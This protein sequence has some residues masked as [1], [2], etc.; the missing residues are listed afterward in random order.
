MSYLE[1]EK[2]IRLDNASKLFPSTFS[3]ADTKVFRSVCELN[4][5]VDPAILQKA[6]DLTLETFPLYR[7]VLR[8]GMFW[9]YLEYS[10]IKPV[11]TEEFQAVCAP[12]YLGHKRN[13]LFRVSYYRHRINLEVFHVLSDGTG[14]FL[15]LRALVCNYLAVRQ[16]SGSPGIP[17]PF[18]KVS[19][20]ERMDDSFERHYTGDRLHEKRDVTRPRSGVRAYRC[21]GTRLP[22]NRIALIEGAMSAKAVLEQAHIYNTTLTVFISALLV[23][24]IGREMPVRRRGRPI[25][26][27]VPINLRQ[28]FDSA[29]VRNFFST[30]NVPYDSRGGVPDLAAV[31]GILSEGFKD[32]L[33]ESRLAGKLDRFMRLSQNPLV[34]IMPL[35][36]KN[37]FL[38]IGAR[39]ADRRISAVISNIGR[40]EM[41]R[42]FE[43]SIRQFSACVG[44]RYIKL[45]LGTYRDR[46]VVSFTSPFRETNVQR[47]FFRLLS[48]MGIDIE[49]SSNL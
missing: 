37:L 11:V 38:K 43:D 23:Y 10:G 9:Y 31:I 46:L 8:R 45:T 20:S 4:E 40:V 28:Y 16:D 15:F 30:M 7:T 5:P 47:R 49:I 39:H 19:V 13:L 17:A 3:P 33:T 22:E 25:V 14:A 32:E 41:P 21:G 12:I 29:T 2:W 44:G 26:L 24:S 42:E 35:P 34:R 18:K 27:S 48:D 36:L 6:L 1:E